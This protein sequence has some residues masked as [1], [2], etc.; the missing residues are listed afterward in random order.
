MDGPGR[1]ATSTVE[2]AGIVGS[3]FAERA[4]R[5]GISAVYWN[6]PGKYHGKIKAFI[7]AVRSGGIETKRGLSKDMPAHP[8]LP[9]LVEPSPTLATSSA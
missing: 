7:D 2:A 8:P 3:V 6:R 4:S 9:G 1:Y 5:A